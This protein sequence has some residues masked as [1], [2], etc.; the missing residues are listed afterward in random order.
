[1]QGTI[2]NHFLK[3]RSVSIDTRTLKPNSIFFGIKGNNFDG[4]NFIEQAIE[5]GATLCV[6]DNSKY[7]NKE[8]VILVK[9]S[10]KALQELATAYRL[11]LN[12]PIIAIA[13]SNGK[14]TTKELS[15]KVL[16]QKYKCYATEGN[17]NNHI[18]VPLTLLSIPKDT[19]IAIVE[20][21]ANKQG[22]N[23]ELCE[24]A[25]PNYGLITN[26]GKDHLEGFGS[27][28]GVIEANLELF[29]FLKKNGGKMFVHQDDDILDQHIKNIERLTYGSEHTEVSGK[30]IEANPLIQAIWKQESNNSQHIVQTQL[31]GNYNLP[32]ILAAIRIGTQF[33]V[34]PARINQAIENYQPSNNRSQLIKINSTTIILDAYNANPSSMELALE[35][36]KTLNKGSKKGVILGDMLELGTYAQKEHEQILKHIS[37]LQLDFAH[38]IGREF[39]KFKEHYTKFSFFENTENYKARLSANQ[40]LNRTVLIKGSRSLGLEVIVDKL[41]ES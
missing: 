10:L 27:I 21:G 18:G 2:L 8:N 4:N 39:Y 12:I 25:R 26:F 40:L 34:E 1:M 38:L 9:N 30:I 16:K 32:N 13:G 15:S 17:L 31:T 28:N 11:T 7:Q 20:L 33:N 35:S 3:Y 24:I 29:D 6:T 22:D 19:E 14:T 23:A 37:D 36:F 5:N 41:R